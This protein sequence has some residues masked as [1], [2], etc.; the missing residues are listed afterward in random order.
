MYPL[1]TLAI[2][3][4][5]HPKAR[6]QEQAVTS[7][8]QARWEHPH[9]GS[10]ELRLSPPSISGLLQGIGYYNVGC[11]NCSNTSGVFTFTLGGGVG[12]LISD[13]V[14][15]G[16]N[17]DFLYGR[18][19]EGSTLSGYGIGIGPFLRYWS[20]LSRKT[21]LVP[22]LS[23]EFRLFGAS[24][25]STDST[26]SS[27]ATATGVQVLAQ[28]PFEFFLAPMWSLRIGPGY[29]FLKLSG[30]GNTDVTIHAVVLNWALATYF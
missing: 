24:E 2:L 13:H 4:G 29:Q 27:S 15:L 11:G 28:L 12:Y 7:D 20:W 3:A 1:F 14:E 23:V 30:D 6:A 8:S 9:A 26:S 22:E 10:I 5:V 19:S 16:G 18:I 25:D 17:L 21:A